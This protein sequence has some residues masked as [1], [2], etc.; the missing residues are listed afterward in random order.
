MIL[1]STDLTF[2]PMNEERARAILSWRYEPPYGIYNAS[3]RVERRW[4]KLFIDPACAYYTMVNPGGELEAYCCFGREA[5]VP[6]GD[7][8]EDA[9]DMG[10]GVHPFNTGRGFGMT[11]VGAVL[12]FARSNY[13]RGRYRVT[14]ASF[15]KRALR[16]WSKAGFERKHEFH[17]PDNGFWFTILTRRSPYHS[18]PMEQDGEEGENT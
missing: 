11:Y 4:I 1:P 5:R 14:V 12:D 8:R 13:P 7:Y 15:N 2:D 18:R 6:G 17:R 10:L 9:L 3:A 16:V